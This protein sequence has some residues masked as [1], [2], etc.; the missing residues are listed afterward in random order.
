MII[1]PLLWFYFIII[2]VEKMKTGFMNVPCPNV[3]VSG[4]CFVF[5]VLSKDAI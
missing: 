3:N 1:S 4:A 2:A 5:K